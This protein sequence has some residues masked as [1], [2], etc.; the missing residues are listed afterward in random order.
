MLNFDYQER[1]LEEQRERAAQKD[2]RGEGFLKPGF[3]IFTPKEGSNRF[4]ILPPTWANSKHYGY[5]TWVHYNIGPRN[6]S[7][8]CSKYMKNEPCPICEELAKSTDKNY[9]N[10]LKAKKKVLVWVIDRDEEKEGPKIFAMASTVDK[11]FV[12]QSIDEENGKLL[13]I[14]HP[15]DGFDVSI[16]RTG[17]GKTTKWDGEKISRNPKP[18]S[19]AQNVEAWLQFIVD[20]PIPSLLVYKEYEYIK[21]AFYGTTLQ[22][23]EK[24]EEVTTEHAPQTLLDTAKINDIMSRIKKQ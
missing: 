21:T 5:D 20:N 12:L 19:D 17:T 8:L 14:D 16:T 22:V 18:L 23:E 11:N 9:I 3:K 1:S 24:H 13:F 4:R 2:G 7:Y 15:V 6:S 10:A